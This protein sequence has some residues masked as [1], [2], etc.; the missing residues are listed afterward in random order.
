MSG[1]RKFE[2]RYDFKLLPKKL[3]YFEMHF[4]F[5][6]HVTELYLFILCMYIKL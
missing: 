2:L 1:Y 5:M 3:F 4:Y 6:L